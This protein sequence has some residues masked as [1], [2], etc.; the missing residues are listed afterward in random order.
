MG[1]FKTRKMPLKIRAIN[2]RMEYANMECKRELDLL[3]QSKHICS[4]PHCKI[5]GHVKCVGSNKGNRKFICTS[6]NHET[7]VHF[8]TSTSFEAIELYRNIMSKNLCLL[9]QTNSNVQG[10]AL[11]NETSRYFVEFAQ[12]ALY[13][14]I[15]QQN[16]NNPRI[17]IEKNANLI[18]IFFDLSG[19]KLSKNSAIILA[20]IEGEVI[21]EIVTHSN[22]LNAH[23]L[24]SSIKDR[25]EVS[26]NTQV[27]FITDGE[28]CFVD[29]I[30]YFFPNAIHIRQFHKDSCKGLV[31]IH[32]KEDKKDYTMR[33]L[34]DAVLKD[35]TPS[36]NVIKQREFK[37][38]K[39]IDNKERKTKIKYSELSSEVIIWEGTVYLPRG[40]RRIL[41][42]K[43]S[44]CKMTK[45]LPNK[46][47]SM[48]DTPKPIFK[49]KIE[50]AKKL[51]ITQNCFHMLRRIFGGLYITSNIVETI[52]NI[53]AKLS[54]HRTMK[55]GHRILVCV[56]YSHLRL[57][58]KKKQELINFFK[59]NVITYDFIRENVLSGSGKQKNKLTPLS[60]LDCINNAIST[61][62]ELIICYCDR[63]QKFT[64]RIIEPIKIIRNDYNNMVSLEAFCKLRNEKR[65]FYLERIR[66]IAVYD[67]R[68]IKI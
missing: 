5:N 32:F 45:T 28:K 46:N 2:E 38:R 57:K 23:Q 63:F 42:Q 34:W 48:R 33:C 21:F 6:P 8:S 60:Y 12:Q 3:N 37:A 30:R 4:C 50:D 41:N 18:T 29:S 58:D 39:R 52:F 53:K 49:G 25:L 16:T 66:D 10:T 54:P 19:S 67:P 59:D 9:A 62:K 65:V 47:T 1:K 35:G 56:L 31:Y 44:A 14:F 11:Y 20:K 27:V 36:K 51:D 24:I 13:D 22:Y 40:T 7:E 15:I 43:I 26:E 55:Y 64:S 68:P 17:K 61:G